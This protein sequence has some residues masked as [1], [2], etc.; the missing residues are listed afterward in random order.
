MET[1][2][3]TVYISMKKQREKLEELINK[4][5]PKLNEKIRIKTNHLLL[6]RR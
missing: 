5:P 4:K 3:K 1:Q 6:C 2:E